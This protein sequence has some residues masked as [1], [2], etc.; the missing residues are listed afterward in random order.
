MKKMKSKKKESKKVSKRKMLEETK[1]K[2]QWKMERRK[3]Y[4]A[5]S[6]ETKMPAP[7]ARSKFWVPGYTTASGTKVKGIW[8]KSHAYKPPKMKSAKEMQKKKILKPD[9]GKRASEIKIIK[10]RLFGKKAEKEDIAKE[11]PK[12]IKEEVVKKIPR[13]I[14][15]GVIDSYILKCMGVTAKVD[16]ISKREEFT[17][18][19]HLTTPKISETTQIILNK[20]KDEFISEVESGKKALSFETGRSVERDIEAKFKKAVSILIKK[21]FP[22]IDN[23]TLMVLKEWIIQQSI[24]MGEIEFLLNDNYLEE[25]VVNNSKENILVYHKQHGWLKTN[26]RLSN[27]TTIRHYA[28]MIGRDVGKDIN[29]LNPLL[30]A[31]LKTGDRVN[32]VLQPISTKGNNITIRKFARSPWT[33]VDFIK[34][35]TMHYSAAAFIWLAVQNELSTLIAGGTGSGKTSTLNVLANFFPPNQRIISIE[36]TREIVLPRSL[37]W[38]PLETRLPNPEGKGGISMLDLVINSL[39]MRPD[40]IIVGEIRRKAEAEVLFEAMQT[41]HSVYATLHANNAEEVIRRLTNPPIEVPKM[42]LPSLSLI[43]IQNRNRRTNLRRTLQL[44]EINAQGD[45]NVFMQLDIATDKFKA[46]KKPTKIF[47]TL[48]LYT[49]MNANE[50]NSD[51]K[52][53]EQILK[54]IVKSGVRDVHDLGYIFAKYYTLPEFRITDLEKYIKEIKAMKKNDL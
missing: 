36:D 15:Y 33:I 17:K 22:D 38:V 49:G 7:G 47:D 54:S 24:G 21:Y 46:I 23:K 50:I 51:L 27:E 3:K 34:S 20:L 4:L 25:I 32:S 37:H 28:T 29:L 44:A 18:I 35:K 43:M 9:I 52:D 53:K 48:N 39:R 12:K 10:E 1:K 6:D 41:G 8:R 19:Y 42:V 14:K 40:R 26:I 16:I 2:I 11:I 5:S 30:D 31:H 45:A 13:E